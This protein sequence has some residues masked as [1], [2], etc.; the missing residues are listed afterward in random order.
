MVKLRKLTP[1][2]KEY[3]PNMDYIIDFG[4]IN[5]YF[6]KKA[7]I[8]LFNEL[9]SEV[10]NSITLDIAELAKRHSKS[11]WGDP[12]LVRQREYAEFSFIEGYKA[13]NLS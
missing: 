11:M 1:A 2:E 10:N 6:S 8:E 3:R 4:D 12:V 9:S 5:R 13:F 7:L